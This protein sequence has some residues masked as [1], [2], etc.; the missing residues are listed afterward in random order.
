MAMAGN[1]KACSIE[2]IA[3]TIYWSADRNPICA[4]DFLARL[5]GNLSKLI[6]N[7]V[8]YARH[9]VTLTIGRNSSN[10]LVQRL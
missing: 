8:K 5:F 7:E 1:G 4:S 9:G 2:F 6:A 10:T 3:T